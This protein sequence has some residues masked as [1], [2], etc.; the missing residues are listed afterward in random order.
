MKLYGYT[1]KGKTKKMDL[2][3]EDILAIQIGGRKSSIGR[4]KEK[5]GV[6]KSYH[7]TTKKKHYFRRY[8]KRCIRQDFKEEIRKEIEDYVGTMQF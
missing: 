3:F 5:S 6:F 4:F 1:G 7:R 8:H 2:G